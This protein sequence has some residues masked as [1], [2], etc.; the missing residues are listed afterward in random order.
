MTIPDKFISQGIWWTVKF[1]PDI[2]DNGATDYDLCEIRIR[3]QLPQAQKEATFLHEIGHTINTSI[4]HALLDSLTMQIYQVLK[5][6]NLCFH[7]NK[8]HLSG[9]QPRTSKQG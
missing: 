4:D 8:E 3:E 7:S 9:E 2:E 1:T 6:N 5:D